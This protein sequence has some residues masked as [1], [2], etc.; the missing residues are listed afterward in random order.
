MKIIDNI[1]DLQEELKLH[2]HKSI[3]YV[4][5]MG[6]LHEGHLSL[7]DK[8]VTS[9]EI[10]VLSI[11]V[12]PLQFGPNEDYDTY[13]RDVQRD[14]K[15]ANESGVDIVFTPTNEVMYPEELDFTINVIEKSEVLCGRNR[16]GHFDGVVTVLLKLFNIIQ[17]TNA[18][19]GMKD[20]Q[21][22]AIVH[23]FV[24]Q[25]NLPINIIGLATVRENTGLAKS[26]RN[27]YLSNDEKQ[28]ANSL[29]ESLNYG[30]DLIKNKKNNVNEI[31]D[32][33]KQKFIE[34]DNHDYEYIELLSFPELKEETELS[35]TVI[36]AIAVKYKKARLIDNLIIDKNG[37]I[38][39]KFN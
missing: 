38:L 9:N 3:G 20:A 18:Y 1:Y 22:L 13:P 28:L 23:T 12:N 5:T 14:L 21:Q 25:F 37:N 39:T 16:P 32:M 19:F 35:N 34:T 2:K 6:F 30:A 15:L 26:S 11:Y 27:V 7:I 8:S 4:P 33:V 31:L 24:K 29:L 17:P 36:L 10:T